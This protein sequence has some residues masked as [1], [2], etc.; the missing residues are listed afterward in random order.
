[1]RDAAAEL[2]F[3]GANRGWRPVAGHCARVAE[4]EVDVVV[5]VDVGEMRARRRFH[6]DGKRAR[7]LEHPVHRHTAE[8]RFGCPLREPG[9]ARVAGDERALLGVHRRGE[10][11]S[12]ECQAGGGQGRR[13]QR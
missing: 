9:G 11:R 6:V 8:E 12:V 5:P 1:M 4:A 2:P 10:A 13:S 3:D 7:P